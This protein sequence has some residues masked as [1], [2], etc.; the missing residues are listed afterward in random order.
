MRVLVAGATGAFGQ[1]LVAALLGAGHDVVALGRDRKVVIPGTEP[2]IVDA[3]DRDAMLGSAAGVEVDVVVHQLTALRKVP[4][5]F[6]DMELT[7]RLRTEGTRNLLEMARVMGAH[8]FVTQSMV[9]GYGFIDHG[10]R[11]L[12]EEDRFGQAHGSKADPIVAAMRSTE[13]QAFEADGIDG[14]ALRYG[15]FYGLSGSD[16]VI[17]A[18]RAGKLP[19][20]R[21][22]GTMSWIH[23]ADAANATVAA[24]EKGT[25]G[26]AY[27]IVDDAPVTWAEMFA[28][29]ARAAGTK[30]PRRLP[31]WMI[32]M[33]APY[34]AT[35]M[36]DTSMRVSNAKAKAELGW[37]PTMPSYSE[38]VA[39][40]Q[41]A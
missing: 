23:L 28:A 3:L 41:A 19:T 21:N 34:F 7:N 36:L 22:T 25:G 20:H 15:A 37:T 6:Q 12:T 33:A 29:H 30:P 40:L 17:A 26:Q 14:I 4:A 38:G 11:V 8:R 27:N 35:L 1:P 2:L 18:L 39:T 13:K 32:R 16:N 31:A 5:K 9:P 10:N 24:I